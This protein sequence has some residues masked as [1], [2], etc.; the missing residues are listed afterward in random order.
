MKK[1]F[2]RLTF[3]KPGTQ[4]P[5][6]DD[7]RFFVTQFMER[8]ALPAL[9]G[10]SSGAASAWALRARQLQAEPLTAQQ[11]LVGLQRV[12]GGDHFFQALS[13][14]EKQRM[15]EWLSFVSV[16]GGRELIVQDERSDYTLLVLEGVVGVDRIQPGGQRI[17]L[18]EAREGDVLGE[19][20]LSGAGG[21]RFASCLSLVACKLAVITADTLDELAI[22]EPRAGM[23]LMASAN[24]QL[25]LR[26]RQL[27]ARLAAVLAADQGQSS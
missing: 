13:F 11:G 7:E 6:P 26:A 4:A 14:H 20:A 12:W 22:E 16:S 1:L 9:P 19:T 10:S 3:G 2:D 25:S 23:A 18:A 5:A 24:R 8:P 15:A 17:R 27:S 21:S